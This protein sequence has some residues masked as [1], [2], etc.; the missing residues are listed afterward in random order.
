[1]KKSPNPFHG[2][3]TRRN[4]PNRFERLAYEPSAEEGEE[5]ESP[6]PET[7]LISEQARSILSNNDSPDIPYSVSI[8]PYRGCEHGCVYC[9]ARTYHEYL[10]L[11]S[12]LD[13]ETRIYYKANAAQLLRKE[14]AA[15]SYRPSPMGLCGATDPYQPLERKLGLTRACLEVLAEFNH[16]ILVVTKNHL[17]AR[18]I[19]L[20]SS[21]ARCQA[22]AVTLSVTTL[23][24]DITGCLEPRTSRPGKRLEAI[25]RLSEAGIPTGVM[26]APVI[27]GL[28]DHEIPLILQKAADSGATF[29]SWSLLRLPPGVDNLFEDWLEA[30]FPSKKSKIL[31]RVRAMRGGKLHEAAFHQ[32][33]A[34]EGFLAEEIRK[35]FEFASRKAGLEFQGPKLSVNSFRQPGPFQELLF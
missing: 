14:L 26:I 10:G 11:S 4:L 6:S 23:A 31:N 7:Q 24:P 3:G 19:D 5:F 18:D 15:E 25:R 33:M 17:V 35:L 12:G 28:T 27:P 32:R 22:A 13:F 20:L 2:R 9:Y 1:M 8:N 16:P 21:L 29:A 30:H 34:G